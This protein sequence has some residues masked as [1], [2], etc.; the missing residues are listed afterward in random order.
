MFFIHPL[1]GNF[2]KF[3]LSIFIL[4]FFLYPILLHSLHAPHHSSLPTKEQEPSFPYWIYHFRFLLS[5]IK[6][7][8]LH[9]Q[10]YLP[11]HNINWMITNSLFAF[12]D[13][14]VSMLKLGQKEKKSSSILWK[15]KWT[16]QIPHASH[17]I[18]VCK[19]SNT[20]A[21]ILLPSVGCQ[22]GIADKFW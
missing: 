10:C 7:N 14:S 8:S 20:R 21:P 19:S 15:D 1:Y 22:Y 2:S 13:F 16:K 4:P 6:V 18:Q 11:F 9:V 12:A 3:S 17:P 5:K